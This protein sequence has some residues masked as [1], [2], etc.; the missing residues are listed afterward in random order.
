MPPVPQP[1]PQTKVEEINPKRVIGA[2]KVE[3]ALVTYVDEYGVQQVQLAV[4]GDKNVHLLEGRSMGLSKNTTPQGLASD[5][6]KKG[7]ME[8]LQ[9]LKKEEA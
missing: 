8:S 7:I 3:L 4:I 1:N 5:W 6:L 9:M 2:K